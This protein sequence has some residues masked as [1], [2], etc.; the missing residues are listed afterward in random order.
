MGHTGPVTGLLYLYLYIHKRQK[1]VQQHTT[2]HGRNE[3][4]RRDME[5]ETEEKQQKEEEEEEEKQKIKKK[6]NK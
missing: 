3:E 1:N 4:V 6:N 2:K 5:K